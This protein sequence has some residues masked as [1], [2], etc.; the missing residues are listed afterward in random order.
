M[1]TSSPYFRPAVSVAILLALTL[2]GIRI[3]YA[4]P[5][6]KGHASNPHWKKN[7][8]AACHDRSGGKP[9]AIALADI[10]ALCLKCHDGKQA[11][12]EFHPVGRRF[13]PA[14]NLVKPEGWPLVND[15]LSCATCHAIRT[16]CDIEANR[17][18]NPKMLREHGDEGAEHAP[19]CQRCHQEQAY[20]KLNPH[21]MLTGQGEIVDDACLFC[22]TKRLDRNLKERTGKPLLRSSQT[23]LCH[24]CHLQ[25]KDPMNQGHMGLPL[26]PDRMVTMR[27]KEILGLSANP[28]RQYLAQLKAA[29]DPLTLLVP[30]K[31]NRI[32]CS[33][34]HNPHQ[35][36]VFPADS[37]LDY[38]SMR[39]NR[40]NK[41]FS[42]M[43]EQVW[44][45]H[46]HEM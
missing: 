21:L 7:E 6:V 23:E 27:A 43:H 38:R 11:I 19:F 40:Q 36:G 4:A 34:C 26:K 15:Q 2:C 44:C 20:R 17:L 33:T 1:Q 18:A 31:D 41:L 37:P 46:C 9:A 42:P 32:T 16:A 3:A 25:H 8:C 24:D 35:S 14:E 28:S 13:Q 12:R 39:L 45:R 22:H 30:D 29:R 10:D 5:P